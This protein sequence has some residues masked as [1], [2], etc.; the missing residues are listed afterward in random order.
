MSN[1]SVYNT[2]A[3]SKQLQEL[4]K[5]IERNRL[6]M[7]LFDTKGWVRD[8]TPACLACNARSAVL[9]DGF[10]PL[11][12]LRPTKFPQVRD[13]EKALKIQWEIHANGLMPMNIIVARSDRLYGTEVIE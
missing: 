9:R 12:T 5:Q 6:T 4:R 2:R 11:S 3:G 7:P 10:S 8:V 1:P 13:F